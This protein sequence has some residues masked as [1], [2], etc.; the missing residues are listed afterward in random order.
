MCIV[1]NNMDYCYCCYCCCCCCCLFVLVFGVNLQTAV[2]RSQLGSDDIELPT[3]FR[4]CIDYLEENGEKM[5]VKLLTY[6]R[7]SV[8]LCL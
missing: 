8:V 7:A 1:T 3:V 4:E 2:Y 5:K 6:L